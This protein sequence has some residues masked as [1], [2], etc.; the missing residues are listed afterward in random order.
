MPAPSPGLKRVPRWRTMI[1]PPVTVCPANTF[2]PRRLALESRPLRLEPRPLLCAISSA[3]LADRRDADARQLLAVARP[4][5]VAALGLELEHAELRP[6]LVRD[7]L[8]ADDRGRQ[9][10]PLAHGVA[11][12]GQQQR[13]EVDARADVVGQPLHEQGLPLDHA[14]LLSAGSDDCVGH[15]SRS[16][17]RGGAEGCR[18]SGYSVTSASALACER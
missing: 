7:H 9:P 16:D 10:V 14:V 3:P 2:T 18:P 13:L 5:L 1:S 17:D 6:A 8:G 12:A 15:G 11:V 4:A